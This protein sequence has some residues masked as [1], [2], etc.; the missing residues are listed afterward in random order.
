[1]A[2]IKQANVADAQAQVKTIQKPQTP[3]AP[4]GGLD[5]FTMLT[6]VLGKGLA[7]ASGNEM[8]ANFATD[9]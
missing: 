6:E 8:A 9:I 4:V 3:A 2:T 1:M 7:A 5:I